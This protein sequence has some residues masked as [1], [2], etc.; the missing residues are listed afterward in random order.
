[1]NDETCGQI[2]SAGDFTFAWSATPKGST[3][4]DKLGPGSAMDRAIDS[5]ATEQRRIRGV[6]N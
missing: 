6:H 1:V 4:D 5:A 2:I 3:F